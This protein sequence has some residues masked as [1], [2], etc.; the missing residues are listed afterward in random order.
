MTETEA[1][2]FLGPRSPDDSVNSS[3]PDRIF[4]QFYGIFVAIAV[5]V[6][7]GIRSRTMRDAW[8]FA[9]V[10]GFEAVGSVCMAAVLKH[11]AYRKSLAAFALYFLISAV[12]AP[13]TYS[14]G[15]RFSSS[16]L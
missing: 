3:P 14:L 15:V 1:T 12:F 7:A 11:H 16:P 10:F 2:P 13:S 4:G 6:Y 8:I 5:G 9:A